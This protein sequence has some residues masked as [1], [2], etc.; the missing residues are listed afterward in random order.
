MINCPTCISDY[1]SH[2]SALLNLF[3]YS[4][5]SICSTV[6]FSPLGISDH[7]VVSV[8]IV[9]PLNSKGDVPFHRT[10]Y[11]YSCVDWDS[12]C[13]SLRDIFHGRIF[14]ILELLL[15]LLNFVSESRL[16][17]M[18]I[19]LIVNIRLNLIHLHGFQLILTLL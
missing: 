10:G 16:E 9:F 19:S 12:L 13:D 8:S 18:Y 11:D 7:D 15:L 1:E 5:P 6:A 4:N 2:M 3:L 14:L 17:L